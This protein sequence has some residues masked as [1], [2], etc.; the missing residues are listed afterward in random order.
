MTAGFHG[1]YRLLHA[2]T[3]IISQIRPRP[4]PFLS[5][6][7]HYVLIFLSFVTTKSEQMFLFRLYVPVLVLR[8]GTLAI[9]S[10]FYLPTDAQ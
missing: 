10:V 5:L 8:T 7:I 9:L 3:K 2:N 6:R 1:L 4:L